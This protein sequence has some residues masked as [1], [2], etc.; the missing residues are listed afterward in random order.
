MVGTRTRD[1]KSIAQQQADKFSAIDVQ[2]FTK[3]RSA[4]KRAVNEREATGGT[5]PNTNTTQD[6]SRQE[7]RQTLSLVFFSDFLFCFFSLVLLFD[8]SVAF[9]LF[10]LLLFFLLVH[11]FSFFLFVLLLLFLACSRGTLI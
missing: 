10:C 3:K 1:K 7:S 5:A 6:V 8:F 9:P 4:T 2:E 11:L